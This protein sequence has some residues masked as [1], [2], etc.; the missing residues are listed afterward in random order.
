[1]TPWPR[2]DVHDGA[3]GP[4]VVDVV[5]QTVVSRTPRRLAAARRWCGEA[6]AG[7]R[8]SPVKVIP[9][10]LFLLPSRPSIQTL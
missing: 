9:A 3:Q 2:I 6:V 10:T 5:N 1:M 7:L 8:P 4:L